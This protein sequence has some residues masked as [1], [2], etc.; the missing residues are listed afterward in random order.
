[1]ASWYRKKGKYVVVFV[2]TAGKLKALPRDLTRHL[3]G[4]PDHN[5]DYWLTQYEITSGLTKTT[6]TTPDL[7]R[8]VEQY[9]KYFTSRDMAA[10]TAAE[11]KRHLLQHVIPYF[12]SQTPPME[13][14]NAWAT[15]AQ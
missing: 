9:I 4:E 13:D 6:S 8:L 3:D 12:L 1:M 14:P 2:S 5:I 11:H 7:T 10:G 15:D